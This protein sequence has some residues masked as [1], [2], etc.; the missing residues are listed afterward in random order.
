MTESHLLRG[1]QST[2]EI[3]TGRNERKLASNKSCH[4]LVC[5]DYV[6]LIW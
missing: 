3:A 2:P 4:F 6:L 5:T 1:E